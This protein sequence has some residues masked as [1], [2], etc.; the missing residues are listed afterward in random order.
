MTLKGKDPESPQE[1]LEPLF[2]GS[3]PDYQ[4]L[5]PSIP[6][7]QPLPQLSVKS[8]Q[9]GHQ[10]VRNHASSSQTQNPLLPVGMRNN[11]LETS[12]QAKILS[13]D[14]RQNS[15]NMYQKTMTRNQFDHLELVSNYTSMSTQTDGKSLRLQPEGI[16]S[17]PMEATIRMNNALAHATS[18]GN[19][20][21][22]PRYTATPLQPS[23]IGVHVPVYPPPV[24]EMPP[25]V[26]SP[27]RL[28]MQFQGLNLGGSSSDSKSKDSPSGAPCTLYY[29]SPGLQYSPSTKPSTPG[30]EHVLQTVP[31]SATAVPFCPLEPFTGLQIR[32]MRPYP[33]DPFLHQLDE[34]DK[35]IRELRENE[36][37]R[38]KLADDRIKRERATRQLWIQANQPAPQPPRNRQSYLQQVDMSSLR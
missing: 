26:S 8:S 18:Q 14:D 22:E 36:E 9:R 2:P 13:H 24:Q 7:D 23:A 12:I 3:I 17:R 10:S 33:V 20:P 16:F 4:D 29:D 21:S 6:W 11:S 1:E 15:K 31:F 37:L 30:N 38:S 34:V 35:S 27:H 25:N 19:Q 28:T 5:F 32:P